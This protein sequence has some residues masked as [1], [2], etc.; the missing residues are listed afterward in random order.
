M[1]SGCASTLRVSS[2]N[3]RKQHPVQYTHAR[4]NVVHGCR[5]FIT[6]SMST[7]HLCTY[8]PHWPLLF[9]YLRARLWRAVAPHAMAIEHVGSTAV[10]GLTAKPIIDIDIVVATS[11]DSG[12]VRHALTQIGY[13]W[14]GEHGIAGRDAYAQPGGWFHHHLYVCTADALALRNHLCLRDAL[15]GDQGLRQR[16]TALKVALSQ[17]PGIT[18]ADYVAG[19]SDFIADILHHHGFTAAAVKSTHHPN[20]APAKAD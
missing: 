9:H 19:K 15:R 18:M 5:L 3:N 16:Y 12:A 2:A 10:P 8:Q 13:Q 7:I 6:I 20:R 14:R 1:L 11:A 4:T 17:I